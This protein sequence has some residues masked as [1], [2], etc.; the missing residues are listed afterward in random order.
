MA[1][2]RV[3]PTKAENQDAAFLIRGISNNARLNGNEEQELYNRY[4]Q[5]DPSKRFNMLFTVYEASKKKDL[6]YG[7][8]LRGALNA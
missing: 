3:I 6:L 8:W 7:A 1:A 5:A 4:L 2:K